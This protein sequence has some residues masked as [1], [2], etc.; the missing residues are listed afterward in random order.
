MIDRVPR[1]NG[2]FCGDV[3]AKAAANRRRARWSARS[4][5]GG[6]GGEG[7]QGRAVAPGEVHACGEPA[8][9]ELPPEGAVAAGGGR[10]AG[11]VE[12]A[13]AGRAWVPM[14][15]GG[16]GDK[17]VVDDR[18]RREQRRGGRRECERDVRCGISVLEGVEGRGRQDEIADAFELKGKE[19]HRWKMGRPGAGWSMGK[20]RRRVAGGF[21]ALWVV[22]RG[23]VLPA[24]RSP[25]QRAEFGRV[26]AEAAGHAFADH[27]NSVVRM[28]RFQ[29]RANHLKV[30]DARVRRQLVVKQARSILD[31][32][33]VGAI[34][35][36]ERLLIGLAAPSPASRFAARAGRRACRSSTARLAP[37]AASTHTRARLRWE[38]GIA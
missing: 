3:V 11:L 15:T 26:A 35:F 29:V 17:R 36:R 6:V 20:R 32:F 21:A 16:V 22:G 18:H 23:N 25:G 8:A 13:V 31:E 24:R 7:H 5:A 4:A 38:C 34:Q 27:G 30:V 9:Q 12:R 33:H 1:A 14:V 37:G 28:Q 10:R 2:V 19:P